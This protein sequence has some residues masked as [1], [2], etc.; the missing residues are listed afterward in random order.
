MR[1]EPII[2]G[3]LMSA[4]AFSSVPITDKNWLSH[5]EIRTIRGIYAEV[6]SADKAGKLKKEP[7]KCVLHGGSFEID[8]TLYRD[9]NGAIRKYRLSAGS[10]DSTGTAE[11]YYDKKGVPHFTYRTR[12]ASNG[13]KK[14]DRIYFDSIGRHLY[15]NHK[16]EGPG[17]PGSEL[18]E[19]VDNPVADMANLCK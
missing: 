19:K 10:G 6:N 2:A 9:T 17:Y 15:T 8:G 16:E 11:Y 5:P 18:E 13:T 14:R 4:S 12:G 3:C 1:F 7:R